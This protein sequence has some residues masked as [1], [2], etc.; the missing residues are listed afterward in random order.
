MAKITVGSVPTINAAIAS[1]VLEVVDKGLSLGM[2][3]PEP[4]HMCVEAAVC[5]AMGEPHSDQPKCVL[6][7]IRSLKIGMNDHGIWDTSPRDANKVR[8]E[9]LRRVAIAQLGTKGKVTPER[10]AKAYIAAFWGKSKANK[11]YMSDLK[12]WQKDQK[13]YKVALKKH[14]ENIRV[15]TTKASS[16][17]SRVECRFEWSFEKKPDL[18]KAQKDFMDNEIFY[19]LGVKT[20]KHAKAVCEEVVQALKK[21]GSPGCKYLYLTEGKKKAPKKAKAKRSTKRL[22]KRKK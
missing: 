5:Y 20:V 4:G 7:A 14:M 9:A 10:W 18:K 6:T 13:A 19:E 21:A 22:V 3:K 11:E 2:G 8:A 12:D 16:N 15:Q 1:R 17:G